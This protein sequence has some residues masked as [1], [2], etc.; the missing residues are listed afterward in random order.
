MKKMSRNSE[1]RLNKEFYHRK[2][3]GQAIQEYGR[4][5]RV[6][7]SETEN[8]YVCNFSETRYDMDLTKKEFEDY[9]IGRMW[10]NEY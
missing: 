8:Y 4:L 7:L 10:I 3:I 1:L 5:C 6:A 9:L 2:V